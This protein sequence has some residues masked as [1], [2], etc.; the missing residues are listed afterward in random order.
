[1]TNLAD[2]LLEPAARTPDVAALVD[3]RG[4]T[5]YG[6]LRE[7]A[8]RLA[9]LLI[10]D[11]VQPGDRVAIAALNDDA[12]VTSY[13]AVLH[14]GGVAVPLNPHSTPPELRRELDAI[15]PRLVLCG[16]GA[17]DALASVADEALVRAIG[18]RCEGVDREEPADTVARDDHDTA[19]LLFTAGTAGAPK[20][21]MLTH[22]NLASNIRQVLDHPGLALTADDVTLGAL[23]FFHIFGLN[24]VLGLALAAGATTVLLDQF[25][26]PGAVRAVRDHRVTVLAG[27]PAMYHAFLDL[28][29]SAARSDSFESV[30]LAVSGAAALAEELFDGM[31]KRFDVVVHEGYGLT[32]ASPIVTTSAIGRREPAPGSIGPP[33]PGI[34]VRL[35]DA[36]ETDVLPGDPGEIWVRGPNVFPGY[37]RDPEAT[38][39]ALTSDGWLRTGDIAV[40]DDAGELSLV[41]RAK[42]LVIVSGFNVYPAEVEEVLLDHPDVA[43]A[44]VVGEP[45]PRTGEAVVAFVV[46]EP[47]RRP[48]SDVL[49]AHCTRSLA[50]YKCP[51]RVEVVNALPRSFAGKVLRRELRPD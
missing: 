42:D 6:D 33:L 5:T 26:A 30:R 39:G 3:D 49:L 18:N 28:D 15:E 32:E 10:R 31:R 25:E 11:G 50:R 1:V 17:A 29:D 13:V 9:G 36:D 51:A 45:D 16:P 19:V 7:R 20:A 48:D 27:V 37:W 24:A 44:A 2:V 21:A 46:P 23:P 40:I 22:G 8:S 4:P 47:G 14:S 38:A 34:D 41:D 12:F 43:D 35:V